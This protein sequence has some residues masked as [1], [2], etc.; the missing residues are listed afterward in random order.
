MAADLTG[1]AL[2]LERLY[3]LRRL[4]RGGHPVRTAIDQLR[5]LVFGLSL[6]VVTDSS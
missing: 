6:P 4:H 3:R 2:T 5:L 1:L